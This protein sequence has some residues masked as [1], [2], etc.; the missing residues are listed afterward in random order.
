MTV[1][2][3]VSG[4]RVWAFWTRS[5]FPTD[6][7]RAGGSILAPNG[8]HNDCTPTR[9]LQAGRRRPVDPQCTLGRISLLG[10]PSG[11]CGR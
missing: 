5:L 1:T 7:R 6:V 11:G 9:S 4:R 2:T 10:S 3:T 8:L